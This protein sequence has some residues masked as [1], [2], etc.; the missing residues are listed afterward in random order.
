MKQEGISTP[1][2]GGEGFRRRLFRMPRL[3]VA[4][5]VM[6]VAVAVMAVVAGSAQAQTTTTMQI[7]NNPDDNIA[8]PGKL[9]PTETLAGPDGT[10]H[11]VAHDDSRA[12]YRIS[13]SG[14]GSLFGQYVGVVAHINF[15]YAE[16][17]SGSHHRVLTQASRGTTALARPS[18]GISRM[19]S[20]LATSG[21]LTI[22]LETLEGQPYT[23]GTSNSICIVLHTLNGTIIGDNCTGGS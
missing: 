6:A 8:V 13:R 10:E 11:P 1:T 20:G 12:Y 5:M 18:I 7:F 2:G 21:P 17:N 22:E 14:G 19:S 15:T 3:A 16:A 23:V 9:H 4:A